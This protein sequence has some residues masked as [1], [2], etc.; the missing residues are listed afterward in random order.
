MLT[1]AFDILQSI[2]VLFPGTVG[3]T[4]VGVFT[5]HSY[6]SVNLMILL[7]SIEYNGQSRYCI[8]SFYSLY[9]R[10]ETARIKFQY[11]E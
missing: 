11:R 5:Q 6:L 4:S 1:T 7:Y 9:Y 8:F 2:W 3:E 10:T